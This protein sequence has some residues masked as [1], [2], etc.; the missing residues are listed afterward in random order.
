MSGINYQDYG[1]EGGSSS[2]HTNTVPH[3]Y[4]LS[5]DGNGDNKATDLGIAC[6]SQSHSQLNMLAGGT[7]GRSEMDGSVSGGVSVIVPRRTKRGMGLNN[8]SRHQ[9]PVSISGGEKPEGDEKR[10][11]VC[12]GLGQRGLLPL[13]QTP[14]SYHSSSLAT[15]KPKTHLPN[16]PPTTTP[17]NRKSGL[18]TE[19]ESPTQGSY[20]SP[21]NQ[22]AQV[23]R[24]Q[25]T[26]AR[27]NPYK[28]QT[29]PS[30]SDQVEEPCVTSTCSGVSREASCSGST[31]SKR[32]SYSPDSYAHDSGLDTWRKSG[33]GTGTGSSHSHGS[34]IVCTISQRIPSWNGV[35]EEAVPMQMHRSEEAPSPTPVRKSKSGSSSNNNSNNKTVVLLNNSGE[36]EG[37]ESGCEETGFLPFSDDYDVE[38]MS[39]IDLNSD[40]DSGAGVEDESHLSVQEL[41]MKFL[42][43]HS[44]IN[45]QFP[46]TRSFLYPDNNELDSLDLTLFETRQQE[47]RS[48]LR[49]LKAMQDLEEASSSL[50]SSSIQRMMSCDCGTDSHFYDTVAHPDG[51]ETGTYC[52]GNNGSG[53]SAGLY[54]NWSDAG[55]EFEFMAPGPPILSK[56]ITYI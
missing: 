49:E 16:N 52:S 12:L 2:G 35:T 54:W 8:E 20:L 45:S 37:E 28:L 9:R 25:S 10:E 50:S 56:Y 11:G 5:K 53:D 33:V 13:P 47:Q 23:R 41:K 44:H 38:C 7:A 32:H 17:V 15:K 24:T 43:S 14:H 26:K 51:S 55:S 27:S 39:E 29:I 1:E 21:H 22:A 46:P 31:V 40:T 42:L 19:N 34:S 36:S 4:R 18:E 6:R 48:F 30:P 3:N